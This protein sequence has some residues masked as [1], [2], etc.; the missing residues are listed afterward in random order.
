MAKL[1][2]TNLD[3][4]ENQATA[5]A[6]INANN[7]LI[8]TALENTYSRNGDSPNTMTSDLDMNSRR[9][10]N[11][12]AATLPNEPV[13]LAEVGDAI[14]VSS[15]VAASAASAAASEAAATAAQTSA[16][17]SQTAA[18]TSATNAAASATLALSA[19]GVNI[20]GMTDHGVMVAT[21]PS[22][23]TSVSAM[24]DGQVLIGQSGTA[25][26]PLTLTGD[27]TV[28]LTGVT[29]I[30]TSPTLTTPV[31][32]V[33][34][35]TSINKMAVTAPAT[36]STLAVADGKTLTASN[37][38]TLAGT[39][40]TT[41]TFPG[42]SSNVGYLEIPQNSKSA[43]YTT[44]AGDS[45]K[46]IFHPSTDANA[47]TFTIDSNANVAY[48]IGAVL[49]FINTTS[50]VVTI[51][52]TSDTMTLAGTTSTGSRSLAQNGVASAVKTGTTS[53]IIYGAG[54]T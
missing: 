3:N 26:S 30:K 14:A 53:W 20:S 54:L 8:E 9:I 24:T 17:A 2:L 35:A 5:V 4:L 31:L 13:R 52:I 44:V 41:L 25:P 45:G 38:L 36:S 28:S 40:S 10:L 37:T 21:G 46:H 47:R 48:P 11:L 34:T 29:S 19:A 18:S 22:T 6:A 15:A 49:T 51:A 7:A 43:S 33:A 39:D 16:A 27:V 12:P 23:G 1:T 32:G 42:V 50:Q